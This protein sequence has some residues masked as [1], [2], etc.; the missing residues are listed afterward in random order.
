MVAR[1]E[2]AEGRTEDLIPRLFA[3][4]RA[5]LG[6]LARRLSAFIRPDDE[7]RARRRDAAN[8]AAPFAAGSACLLAGPLVG[9]AVAAGGSQ[10][11]AWTALVFTV[12][13]AAARLLVLDLVL[14]DRIGL[15][16]LLRAWAW[17]LVPYV[18]AANPPLTLVAWFL[19][20]VVTWR[21]LRSSDLSSGEVRRGV[22]AAWGTQALFA[23]I[24]WVV[25]NGWVAF[26]ALS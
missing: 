15:P 12:V 25:V 21:L 3:T 7:T 20:G 16:A 4:W 10:R 11:T 9:V 2:D 17:G 24:A 8:R 14:H 13:W 22:L 1:K 26:L 5:L 18:L 6:R 23:A 19:S